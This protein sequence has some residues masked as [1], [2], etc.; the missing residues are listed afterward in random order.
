M[1][2]RTLMML[3]ISGVLI[4]ILIAATYYKTELATKEQ[5]IARIKPDKSCDLQKSACKLALPEGGEVTLSIEPRPIP[6]VKQL[7][8]SV[9]AQT[10]KPDS[11]VVDFKGTTMNMGPNN[12]TL[13]AQTEEFFS[14]NGMLPVCVRN[15][16]EWQAD[17][18]L[19]T[20][21]GIIVAPFIFETVK[22]P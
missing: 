19:K 11:V 16:M 4:A 14:G 17:V 12:V 8:I 10:I 20:E 5:V 15:R 13:K 3:A 18:Y 1:E 6:L 2:K 9:N 21:K 22:N 7:N